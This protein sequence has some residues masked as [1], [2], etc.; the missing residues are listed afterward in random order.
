[1]YA[2]HTGTGF[3]RRTLEQVHRRLARIE[4]LPTAVVRDI[5]E[6][7]LT[8]EGYLHRKK[9]PMKDREEKL[10]LSPSGVEAMQRRKP[11]TT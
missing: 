6:G 1:M 7:K 5:C 4:R 8:K 11:P 10:F 9:R 2:G 3:D